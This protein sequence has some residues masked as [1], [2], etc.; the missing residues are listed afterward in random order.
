MLE[1]IAYNWLGCVIRVIVGSRIYMH[2]S[3]S[4]D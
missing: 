3:T 4:T 2:I 1:I